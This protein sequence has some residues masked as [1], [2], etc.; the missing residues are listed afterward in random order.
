[1]SKEKKFWAAAAKQ[2]DR[3]LDEFISE[4]RKYTYLLPNVIFEKSK[5]GETLYEFTMKHAWKAWRDGSDFG[6]WRPHRD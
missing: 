6:A 3:P 2:V 5:D 1:M 4:M